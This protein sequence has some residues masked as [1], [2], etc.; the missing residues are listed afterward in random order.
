[1]DFIRK[2]EDIDIFCLQEIYHNA[3]EAI[4]ENKGDQFNLFT[5]IENVLTEH[6][7]FFRKFIDGYGLAIFVKNNIDVLHE[8][9]INIYN[10][11]SWYLI[12]IH[13]IN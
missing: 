12:F 2:S 10:N 11:P 7:G 8:N 4:V 13:R 9:S 5:D 6:K 3:K 1:M